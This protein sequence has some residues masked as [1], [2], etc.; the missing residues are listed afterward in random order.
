M[1]SMYHL[2]VMIYYIGLVRL[3]SMRAYWSTDPYM[4]QHGVMEELGM[5]R[6][7][8]LFMWRNFHVYNKEG[9]DVQAEQKDGEAGKDDNS[10]DDNDGILE[11]TMERDVTS[12]EESSVEEED[13]EERT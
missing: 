6:D 9:T 2:I 5:T 4:P 1:S 12:D 11:F 3:P 7:C 13:E 10:D 8:F